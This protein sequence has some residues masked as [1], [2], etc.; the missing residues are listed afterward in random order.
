MTKESMLGLPVRLPDLCRCGD[1][2]VVIEAGR[3]MHEAGL[4]CA[5][6]R[7][8]GWVSQVSF[9]FIAEIV[10]L[11][12]RPTQPIEIRVKARTAAPSGADA[13]QPVTAPCKGK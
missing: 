9:E 2:T 6:G 3:A 1:D 4:R 12:G 13:A 8:R 5:C 11:H 7:H 10:R